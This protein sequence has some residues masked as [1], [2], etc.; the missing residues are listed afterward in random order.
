MG[1]IGSIIILGGV[2]AIFIGEGGFSPFRLSSNEMILT[3]LFWISCAGLVVGWKWEGIGGAI[4]T[5]SMLAF[6]FVTYA[7]SGNFPG[8][9]AFEIISLPGICFLLAALLKNNDSGEGRTG[10]QTP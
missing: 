4:A 2:L 5:L 7:Q 1:R 6:F 10:E 9:W 3:A 8:G